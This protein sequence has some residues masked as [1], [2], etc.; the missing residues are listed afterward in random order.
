MPFMYKKK[1]KL[2]VLRLL[3]AVQNSKQFSTSRLVFHEF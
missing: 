3:L 2:P 1:R